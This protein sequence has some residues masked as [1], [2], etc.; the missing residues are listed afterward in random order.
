MWDKKFGPS[1]IWN[2]S[3]NI[4]KS[5]L[6]KEGGASSTKVTTQESYEKWDCTAM[7]QATIN[8]KSFANSTGQTLNDI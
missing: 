3:E 1:E 2:D 7:N 4:R 6:A 8:A 5:F